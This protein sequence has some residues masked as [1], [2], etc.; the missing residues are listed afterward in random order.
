MN[1]LISEIIAQNIETL[2]AKDV[3]TFPLA[4]SIGDRGFIFITII[5][6]HRAPYKLRLRYKNFCV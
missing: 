2:L 4:S 5:A 3:D 6:V 1:H